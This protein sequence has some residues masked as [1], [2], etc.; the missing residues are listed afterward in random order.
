M[1]TI[2]IDVRLDEL[3]QRLREISKAEEGFFR[4]LLET[5]EDGSLTIYRTAEI[6]GELFDL[7]DKRTSLLTEG[8]D[9]PSV[10]DQAY[11]ENGQAAE[12]GIPET[13]FRVGR[14]V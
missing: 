6:E 12:E 14:K 5:F 2:S 13:N 10:V 4:E 8:P 3:I 1:T 9:L 7:H 11:A